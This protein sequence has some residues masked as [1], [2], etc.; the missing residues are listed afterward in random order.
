MFNNTES[1]QIE[2][3]SYFKVTPQAISQNLRKSG[4]TKVKN[5]ETFIANII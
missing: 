3:A 1:L 5:G 4:F 2:A